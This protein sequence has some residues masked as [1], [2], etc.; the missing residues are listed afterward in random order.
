MGEE[1]IQIQATKSL[2][3]R[4][5]M[6]ALKKGLFA[7]VETS[8]WAFSLRAASGIGL[9]LIASRR[10]HQAAQ[11]LISRTAAANASGASCGRL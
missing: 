4:V 3:L 1:G 5:I 8:P 2:G 7:C 6:G 10:K 9:W 11:A